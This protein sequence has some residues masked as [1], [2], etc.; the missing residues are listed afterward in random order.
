[1]NRAIRTC[2]LSDQSVVVTHTLKTELA[3]EFDRRSSTVPRLIGV[4]ITD[5]IL[6]TLTIKALVSTAIFHEKMTA[7]TGNAEFMDSLEWCHILIL[8]EYTRTTHEVPDNSLVMREFQVF[9]II[10]CKSVEVL[11]TYESCNHSLVV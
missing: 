6:I 11:A 8:S 2:T 3:N 1:M 7:N 9:V 4:K 5:S 10:V